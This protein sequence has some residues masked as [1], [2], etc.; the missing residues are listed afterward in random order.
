MKTSTL[1]A[2]GDSK[3]FTVSRKIII[4]VDKRNIIAIWAQR[5]CRI[6][7]RLRVKQM[8]RP[9][10]KAGRMRFHFDLR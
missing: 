2:V 8:R 1:V 7:R 6:S 9:K 10:R 4:A 3:G 5:K